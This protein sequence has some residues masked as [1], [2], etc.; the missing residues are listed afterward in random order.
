MLWPTCYLQVQSRFNYKHMAAENW[1]TKAA[2]VVLQIL[3]HRRACGSQLVWGPLSS[4]TL[5]GEMSGYSSLSE[6]VSTEMK[7]Q[8]QKLTDE[9]I[10]RSM[11]R[12]IIMLWHL[13]TTQHKTESQLKVFFIVYLGKVLLTK[14]QLQNTETSAM[15]TFFLKWKNG[16]DPRNQCRR[17]TNQEYLQGICRK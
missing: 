8:P 11:K 3:T 2:S 6:T 13:R 7:L 16:W 10:R 17:W 5:L 4:Q 9:L 12:T 1:S 15:I 14:G